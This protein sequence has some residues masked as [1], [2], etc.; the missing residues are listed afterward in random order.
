MGLQRKRKKQHRGYYIVDGEK[1]VSVTTV[2][3]IIHKYPLLLWYGKLGTQE[4]KKESSRAMKIG[5]MVHKRIED[6]IDGKTLREWKSGTPQANA[7]NAF[8]SWIEDN[9]VI[10]IDREL[11]VY[12]REYG[13]A[14]TLDLIAEINGDL[15]IVDFKTSARIYKEGELQLNAYCKAVVE[16][17]YD[18]P[19]A[20]YI[21]RL[22]KN[23]GKYQSKKYKPSS[24]IFEVFLAAQKLWKWKNNKS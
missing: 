3:G 11:R 10:F 23:T 14:G 12:S 17:E 5:T 2:L 21:I 4:A 24:K 1:L 15:A 8:L 7:F 16:M 18:T 20:L 22:D 19:L 9:D 6:Y 13:F